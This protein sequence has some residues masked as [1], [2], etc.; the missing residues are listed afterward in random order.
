MNRKKRIANILS[1]YF[2]N[3][4][5]EVIDNSIEHSGHNNFD[6]TQETHFKIYLENKI[7]SPLSRLETHR[8]IYKL[9]NKEFD[10]GLHA[11][12]IKIIN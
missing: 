5:I 12:E 3:S 7:L 9:L 4:S 1:I 11:L 2:S 6:G 10:T 8:K